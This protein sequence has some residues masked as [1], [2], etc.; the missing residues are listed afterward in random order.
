M[1]AEKVQLVEVSENAAQRVTFKDG[2]KVK[3]KIG[4]KYLLKLDN[5]EVAP[6]NVT[7]KRDGKDLL[8]FF[9]G[10]DKPDLVIQDFFADGMDSQLYGVSEDGQ[11]YAYVRTDGEG[12][13][14][15][16][17]LADG[18]M[19]PIALGGEPLGAAPVVHGEIDESAGFLLWPLLAGAGLIG[20]VAAATKKD[21]HHNG[22]DTTPPNPPTVNISDKGTGTV[23]IDGNTE[24]NATVIV[25]LPDG[26]TAT[27][28]ADAKGDYSIDVPA[29]HGDGKIE[30]RAEDAAGNISEPT[31]VDYHDITPPPAPTAEITD[32][33]TGTITIDGKSEPGSKVIVTLPDGTTATTTADAK[34]DYS[35]DVP[36][37]KAD[38]DITV[39]AEDAAG[40]VSPPTVAPY[41]DITPPAAP[42]AEITDPGTGTITI[43][44]KSEPGSKVIVTLPDGTT[45]TTTADAKGDYS[46]DVPAPKAD[47]DIT[48]K[49]EDAAGNLSPSTDVPYKDIT[50]PAAPTAEITDPGTGTITID[51]KSEPGS[52]VIVTLPDGTTATTT[53]DAKGDYSVDVPAPKADGDITV[54]A[55]DAAG[56]VSPPT[57][58]PYHDITPP[59]APTA[60]I[61]DPGT[62]TIT[63]DG[64]S[65]PGS[66]VIVELPDGTTASTTADAKGDYSISIPAPVESCEIEVRAED[67]AGNISPPTPVAYTD[68]IPPTATAAIVSY[69]DDV[70]PQTG[71]FLSGSTTNDPHPKLNG[72]VGGALGTG[73]VVAVYRDGVR[74]GAAS[75][76]ADGKIW[77]FQDA[78]LV[79]GH[80]YTYTVRVED[81]AGNQGPVSGNFSLIVDTSAPTDAPTLDSVIDDVAPITGAI[82]NGGSTNDPKPDF[83]GSG[84]EPNSKVNIYDNGV[85]VDTVAA[86]ADGKWKYTP[87]SN[88]DDKEHSFQFSDVDAAGN[89]GPKS[90]PFVFTVDTIAPTQ[91]TTILD[92]DDNVAPVIGKIANNGYTN[93]TTP[94]LEGTI[95]D[96]LKAGEK[97]VVLRDGAVIGEATVTGT[98]WSFEDSG[99][100]D[101][102]AYTY[103]ARVEDAA[104]NRG[105]ISE[106][107]TLNI[108]TS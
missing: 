61:T 59:A 102:K 8:V 25:T 51:G 49:A 3:A 48:V 70:A 79:D 38:G 50:P 73:E 76:S 27:T 42:T 107:F 66:K 82:T 2:G 85:L 10:S 99:L 16:L 90:N 71:D 39:K 7:V 45:A 67:A 17:L 6:E 22:G 62:G 20:G 92:V 4:T 47:G 28:T 21:H 103:S 57:V 69:T 60:E 98:N 32:P 15:Q 77:S 87:T 95:S 75:L 44:G 9:Q 58:A 91:S 24:P 65:E 12:F 35:V 84:A 88:L 106:T 36:A 55:E 31:V 54:K 104:G 93:D 100:Q 14:S 89:E 46:V 11:M 29:P 40:N 13:Y 26:T 101:G 53:A 56:N 80:T 72:T 74:L 34:G 52:K 96:V 30:V 97:V 19:T 5:N 86:D 18:E 81:Q 78:G 64:K 83:S 43:D 108:D 68:I 1:S 105:A 41:H 23:T 33:G 63:I 94:K 37:P